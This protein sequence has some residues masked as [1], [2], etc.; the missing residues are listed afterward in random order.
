MKL[1]HTVA[2]LAI[3]T[4]TS[5]AALIASTG[6]EVSEGFPNNT[7]AG[8]FNVTTADGANWTAGGAGN[9]AGAWTG[10]ALSGTQAAVIG[11]VSTNAQFITVDPSGSDGVATISFSWERFTTTTTNLIVQY[12]TDALDGGESWTNAE[13]ID[14]SGAPGGGWTAE[15]VNINQ[16][17]DVKL[18]FFL[19]GAVGSGGS[20]FDDVTVN[21]IPEPSST[22]L[23]G[24]GGLALILRR[25]K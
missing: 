2:A 21:S 15:T 12:T 23:L 14:M 5:Q 10:Q 19:D 24:L 8:G 9:Y 18:R 6:F 4:I 17:G 7:V 13:T 20:S 11:N 25:R 1:Y 22:A 16:S 3:S